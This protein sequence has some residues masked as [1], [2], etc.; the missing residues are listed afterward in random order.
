MSETPPLRTDHDFGDVKTNTG[1]IDDGL[2]T[3][4]ISTGTMV[5]I[6]IAW[7][8]GITVLVLILLF[9]MRCTNTKFIN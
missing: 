7:I 1:D 3:D 5:A 2:P 6:V 8:F 9:M 4:Y